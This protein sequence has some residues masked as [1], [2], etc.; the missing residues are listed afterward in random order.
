[1]AAKTDLIHDVAR[2][3]RRVDDQEEQVSTPKPWLG[4]ILTAYT[5]EPE[6]ATQE[7]NS[8]LRLITRWSLDFTAYARS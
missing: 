2:L 1:M 3:Q 4:P 7:A 5:M 6:R 8:R